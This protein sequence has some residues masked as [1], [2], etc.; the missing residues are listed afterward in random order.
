MLVLAIIGTGAIFTGTN[1]TYTATELAHHIKTSRAKYLVSESAILE[2]LLEAAKRNNIPEDNLWIFDPLSNE[3]P[4]GRRSWRELFD[5]GEKDWVRFN[6]QKTSSTTTAARLFSSG[7][8]GLPKA[9]TIT[10]YGLIG[11][12]EMAYASDPR[13]YHVRA[14][15]FASCRAYI[16]SLTF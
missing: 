1:P 10:H 5:H 15:W 11:Q 14:V 4:K 16:E 8:T 9:V 6:D 13:N 12:H 7:T 2:P 3:V